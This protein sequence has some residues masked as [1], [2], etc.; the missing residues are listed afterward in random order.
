M[1]VRF[2][3]FSCWFYLY[4]IVCDKPSSSSSAPPSYWQTCWCC[5]ASKV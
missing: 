4:T 3:L 5:C 1:I 2:S